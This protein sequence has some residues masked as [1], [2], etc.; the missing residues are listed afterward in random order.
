MTTGGVFIQKH[1]FALISK[2]ELL[3]YKKGPCYEGDLPYIYCG[4]NRD[5]EPWNL[6]LQYDEANY[7]AP[8]LFSTNIYYNCGNNDKLFLALAA[9]NCKS[10]RYKWFICQEEYIST[11]TMEVIK[12]GTWQQNLNYDKL[13]YSLKKLWKKATK[14][15]I[16]KHFKL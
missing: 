10:D 12:V 16:I 14:S 4:Y 11:H 3:G 1:D 6:D 15:E 7:N 9:L 8:L 2:L 5:F 13:P